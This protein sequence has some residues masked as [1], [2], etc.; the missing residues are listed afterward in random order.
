MLTDF[1]TQTVPCGACGTELPLEV[2]TAVDLL[3]GDAVLDPKTLVAMI[4]DG[5]R[6]HRY[7][8]GHGGDNTL[9]TQALWEWLGFDLCWP[10]ALVAAV[11][12]R[13]GGDCLGTAVLP[14]PFTSGGPGCG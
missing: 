6:E 1:D 8:G 10:E 9:G 7:G 2:H 3:Y 5:L 12:H 13:E 14:S 11:R 4:A